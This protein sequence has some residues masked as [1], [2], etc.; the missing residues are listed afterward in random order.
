MEGDFQ[1]VTVIRT[2]HTPV[3]ST[4]PIVRGAPRTASTWVKQ[5]EHEADHSYLVSS[6]F[7]FTCA[8][9]VLMV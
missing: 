4:Q 2:S 8:L 6:Y 3:V 5:L 7:T 9:C 1:I